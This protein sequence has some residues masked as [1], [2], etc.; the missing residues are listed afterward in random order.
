MKITRINSLILLILS[1]GFVQCQTKKEIKKNQPMN[2]DGDFWHA[3]TTNNNQIFV[4]G[5]MGTMVW[6]DTENEVI[7]KA[8]TDLD[9]PYIATL[10]NGF[11]AVGQWNT[12]LLKWNSKYEKQLSIRLFDGCITA[13]STSR[14]E[15]YVAGANKD[16][17]FSD[18]ISTK[19][20]DYVRLLPGSI[21][22]ITEDGV[23]LKIDIKSEGQIVDLVSDENWITWIDNKEKN[24]L[25]IK[26]KDTEKQFIN[27]NGDINALCKIDKTLYYLDE[28]G[29]AQ[30]DPNNMEY[31]YL[32][33]FNLDLK[34]LKMI[35]HKKRFYLMTSEGVFLIP[36][37]I[38]INKGEFQPAD[39]SMY[40]NDVLII[41][42]D[43]TIIRIGKNF[44]PKEYSIN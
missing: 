14:N 6:I 19:H 23:S 21:F 43:G 36:G 10:N 30:L 17:T 13:L 37:K 29:I 4:A 44:E 34:V 39:I 38:K 8:K 25:K 42:K 35:G 15:I 26:F 31:T 28:K 11:V 41:K 9:R 3:I 22:K 16:S 24:S 32:Y 33:D 5:D 7:K 1:V 2:S 40:N 18:T 12:N 20:K 27:P